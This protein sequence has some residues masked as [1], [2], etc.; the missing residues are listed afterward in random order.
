[1]LILVIFYRDIFVN[2][3]N[4]IPFHFALLLTSMKTYL[5]PERSRNISKKI[6]SLIPGDV[7]YDPNQVF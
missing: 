5:K 3:F 7:F 2:N 1:M 6:F 4:D